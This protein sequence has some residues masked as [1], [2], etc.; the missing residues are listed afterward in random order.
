MNTSDQNSISSANLSVNNIRFIDPQGDVEMR[1]KIADI[2]R[3]EEIEKK[4]VFEIPSNPTVYR[5]PLR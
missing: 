4:R 3:E 2:L 1:D 5:N